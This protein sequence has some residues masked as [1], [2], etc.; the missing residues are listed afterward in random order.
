MLRNILRGA[1]RAG[2]AVG[3][4]QHETASD[5]FNRQS[6]RH[7]TVADK[8]A[9][10]IHDRSSRVLD[11]GCGKGG[12]SKHLA[13]R[14]F[15]HLSGCDWLPQDQVDAMPDG[16]SYRRVDLNAEALSAYRDA[17]FDA[18]VA[19]D[20]L[21]HLEN[22]A[23][24]LREIARVLTPGGLAFVSLPNAFNVVERVAWLARGNSTR[25]KTESSPEEFGHISILSSDVLRSLARR[26][27]LEVCESSGGYF[28][29]DGFFIMPKKEFSP[30][31]SYNIIWTLRKPAKA[32][33][34]S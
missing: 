28:Y 30:R 32:D 19:S 31:F 34:S 3:A 23:S 21:E 14:G 2:A 6:M 18:I 10:R 22:P 17:E 20:V 29:L 15:T 7:T 27:G 8:V 24:I 12:L 9:S 1:L 25:Y 11:V 4:A 16:F 33:A 5:G 26:A 13:A